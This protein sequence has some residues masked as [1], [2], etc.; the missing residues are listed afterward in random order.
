MPYDFRP[1]VHQ[2]Q[3]A[4]G[5]PGKGV[6]IDGVKLYI[7]PDHGYIDV[8]AI[9]EQGLQLLS[10]PFADPYQGMEIIS[11]IWRM[12]WKQAKKL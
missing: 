2:T 6:F 1:Y 11:G 5:R 4:N 3:P 8:A 12:M 9:P 7:Y 10:Q